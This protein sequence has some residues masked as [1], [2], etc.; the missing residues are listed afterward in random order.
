MEGEDKSWWLAR[1]SDLVLQMHIRPS[2]RQ[3]DLK[4]EVGLYFS[5][6]PA[7]IHPTRLMLRSVGIDIPAGAKDYAI[8]S[9]YVTP[10]DLEVLSVLPH[11]HYLCRKVKGWATLPD[12]Q[13]R[14]LLRIDDWNFDW[15]GNYRFAEPLKLPAGTRLSMRIE[16][17]NSEGNARNPHHP[18]RRVTYGLNSSDEMGEFHMQVVTPNARDIETLAADYREKY[19]IPDSI[20]TARALLKIDPQSPERLVKLGAVLLAADE[21]DQAIGLFQQALAVDPRYATAHYQMGHAYA[22]K[23][24]PRRAVEE[25]QKVLE[26]DPRHFRAHNN[27]GYWHLMQRELDKAEEH[28]LAAVGENENDLLSRLNLARL[29]AAKGE[30]TT[31]EA[32]LREALKIDPQNE[33]VR[34]SW[35]EARERLRIR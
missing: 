5:D 8:E 23:Q 17:D 14:L 13:E 21:V 32:E 20:A 7:T 26:I 31:V 11:A 16:Y 25:W 9:S 3:E 4:A 10:V 2:G 19:A 33:A 1:H 28:L 29:Y 12:G 15:Q 6:T 35:E 24:D 30:W 34:K 18:P 22:M 27:L